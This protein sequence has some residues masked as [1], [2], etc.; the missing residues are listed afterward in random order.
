M[1]PQPRE[2]QG[3]HHV[4]NEQQQLVP[5]IDI[6]G[7][8]GDGG[9]GDAGRLRR[10]QRAGRGLRFGQA[11]RPVLPRLRRGRDR[12]GDQALR[13]GVLQGRRDHELD[14]R[15]QLRGQ[16]LLVPADQAGARRLR[17]PPAAAAGQER[18]GGRPERHHRSGQGRL[19]P[20]R[21]QVAHRG[22]QDLRH[23]DDR[24]PAVLLLPQ[25]DAGEGQGRSPH[26]TRRVAGGR[27]QAHHGQGQGRLPRQ[28]LH[29]GPEQRDL[30]GRRRH[31]RHEQQDRLPHG[32]R[33][34]R[35]QAAPPVV[36]QRAR[37][38][39][40]PDRLLGPVLARPGPVRHPVGRH[41]V[42][43][44]DAEGARRRP[45]DLS[46]PQHRQQ[47]QAVGLQRR[48][49]D[50]RQRQGRERRGGQGVREMA[51]DRPEEVP[52]GL[53][54]VLRLPHPAAHLDRQRGHQ[55]QVRP[56]RRGRQ[57]LH[58]LRPLRQHRLRPDDDHR[59]R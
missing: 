33:G 56:P 14:H 36:H 52:G 58:R 54:A 2:R 45:G 23:P 59:V 22:R 15:Q 39:G 5:P 51:V 27:R 43:A 24:R 57:A 35:P 47:R 8:R 11:A 25:V 9:R 41:V 13:E 7:G 48:L 17:V 10:Q 26:H 1:E 37:P 31:P 40:R 46:L 49:V 16:A 28:R 6:P 38:A 21:H 4:G 12:A 3:R 18:S 55:A 50:V 32:R 20:G 30:V 44:G 29:R 53:G 19:Q 42:H 34:P